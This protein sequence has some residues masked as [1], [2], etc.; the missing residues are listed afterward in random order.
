MRNARP[1]SSVVLQKTQ[2]TAGP[3]SSSRPGG[4]ESR[5]AT[6][7]PDLTPSYDDGP[8]GTATPLG[9]P[10]TTGHSA[11]GRPP[12][13]CSADDHGPSA[14]RGRPRAICSADDHG[15][16]AARTTTGHLQRGRPRAICSAD[17]FGNQGPSVDDLGAIRRRPVLGAA[18][19]MQSTK[20]PSARRRPQAIR[21][22]LNLDEDVSAL[23]NPLSAF[24]MQT[25]ISNG[26]CSFEDGCHDE[27]AQ[28]LQAEDVPTSTSST[29]SAGAILN[30]LT[31]LDAPEQC[32]YSEISTIFQRSAISIV[33]STTS[34]CGNCTTCTTWD[35]G[36]LGDVPARPAHGG[37]VLQLWE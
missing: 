18:G 1:S 5:P 37:H 23:G 9:H 8:N 28:N 31:G 33:F 3:G 11:C 12:A 35:V 4:V 30:P 36:H 16:S 2:T 24:H 13:I 26:C 19:H 21:T 22:Q 17:D 7:D 34:T 32:E 6:M 20:G 29:N 10:R 27:H 14:A 25:T 15:P